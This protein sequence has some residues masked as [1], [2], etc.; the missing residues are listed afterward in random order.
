MLDPKQITAVVVT[1]G[2]RDISAVLETLRPF[3][4]VIVWDNG[5]SQVR[6]WDA[7]ADD[8]ACDAAPEAK[9]YGRYLGAKRARFDTIYVQDDDCITDPLEILRLYN[10]HE[11]NIVMCNMKPGHAAAPY[12]QWRIKLV[13]FGAIFTKDQMDFSRYLCAF[14]HDEFFRIECDRIFTAFN[15][16]VTCEVP[17]T[18]MEYASAPDRLWRLQDHG[19]RMRLVE[20][21]LKEILGA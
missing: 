4:E 10:Q 8:W 20:K 1:K 13:G 12:Y 11:Q 2:D 16:C 14:D 7:A 9:V 17:V 15:E 19:A 5:A 3:G 18:D 6:T 21:R